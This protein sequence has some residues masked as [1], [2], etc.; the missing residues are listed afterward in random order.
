[1]NKNDDQP[2]LFE[3]KTARDEALARVAENAGPW[4]GRAIITISNLES[5][6]TGIGED[7]RLRVYR[8]IGPPH[9]HNAWGEV[10]KT[11]I[12]D[13]LLIPTGELRHMR[14]KKSHARKSPV[15]RRS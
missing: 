2:E 5:G 9:H 7:L 6:W 13:K 3:A 12:Q 11:C 1:M 10:I 14:T 4:R 15:Y 8:R